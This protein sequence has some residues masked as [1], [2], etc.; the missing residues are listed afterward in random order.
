[1]YIADE[2]TYTGLK[3]LIVIGVLALTMSSADSDINASCVLV[4]NDIFK[5]LGI[6]K[7]IDGLLLVKISSL[8]IGILGIIIAF[9]SA[10][11]VQIIFTT[12]AYYLP[13]VNVPFIL[14]VFG[15][16]S[17]GAP[18][19][20]GMAAGII[21]VLY[22]QITKVTMVES[23]I[24]GMIANFVFFLGSHYIL[25]AEGGWRKKEDALA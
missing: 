13:I 14:A 10:N 5:P 9:Y 22:C 19:Y 17:K 4:Y 15:F 20:I 8:I 12:L 6:Y 16:R 23:F 1:M 25:R 24:P 7:N 11:L 3:G 18:V 21:T 2:Y